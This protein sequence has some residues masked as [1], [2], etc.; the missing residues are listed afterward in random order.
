MK[1]DHLILRKIIEFVATCHF[2]AKIINAPKSVSAR[3]APQ[4]Q[5]PSWI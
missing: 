4:T 5:T 1:F 2:K 3:A